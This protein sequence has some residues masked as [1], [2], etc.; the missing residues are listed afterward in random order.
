M[1][2]RE[3]IVNKLTAAGLSASIVIGGFIL[4]QVTNSRDMPSDLAVDLGQVYSSDGANGDMVTKEVTGGARIGDT[5]PN[6]NNHSG[7]TYFVDVTFGDINCRLGVIINSIK[8]QSCHK[9]N[10]LDGYLCW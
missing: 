7:D 6:A 5:I 2:D 1:E 3:P 8:W 4:I 10:S 9:R